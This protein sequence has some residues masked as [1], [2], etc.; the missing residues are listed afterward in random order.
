MNHCIAIKGNGQV[1]G[2]I[3]RGID[4]RCTTHMRTLHTNGPH[5]TSRKE[6]GYQHRAVQHRM[7]EEGDRRVRAEQ[8][9][10]VR[11]RMNQDLEHQLNLTRLQ[12]RR[13]M[14]LLIREQQD[15]I[16]RTGVNPDAEADRR[17]REQRRQQR[18]ALQ[19]QWQNRLH[20]GVELVNE[21]DFVRQVAE[22]EANRILAEIDRQQAEREAAEAAGRAVQRRELEEFARDNQNVHTTVAVRQTKD[23]VE[24]ILKISVPPEYRW[25]MSE[26]SKTPGEIIVHCRL[27][28]KGAW[29][30]QAKYC[31]DEEIYEL[32]KGIYGKVL[33]G[34]WQYIKNSADKE[35]LYKVLKQEM[36][37]NVGMCAQGNLTRL[38][39]ILC[40]YMEGIGVQESPAEILGRKLP[41]LMEIEDRVERL[42]QA[43]NLLTELGIPENQ[44]MSWVEPLME[45]G[46]SVRI[47][48]DAVGRPIGFEIMA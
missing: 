19:A 29:Q 32:G 41:Q 44:W 34:V 9:Q 35:D 4:I 37:D 43:F 11:A 3:C 22:R 16:R 18:E 7:I 23:M 39:N 42:K 20:A 27:T 38:C 8:D 1:C 31:Q 24:R 33:D 6:L 28:P 12:H 25:N 45:D 48:G 10:T 26:C 46:V 36:E 47:K 15:E 5:T 14:D 30:M 40:G 17:R 13:E 2:K 21:E